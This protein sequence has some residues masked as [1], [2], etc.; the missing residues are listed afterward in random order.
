MQGDSGGPLMSKNSNQW[1][2]GGV[3]SFGNG[4]GREGFPGVYTRVS[5]YQDWI[6]SQ[7]NSNQPGFIR[8]SVTSSADVVVPVSVAMVSF[9]QLL[10]SLCVLS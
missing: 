6:N 8:V 10:L 2:Q 3:V 9:L 5:E 7:I 1:V 4:C